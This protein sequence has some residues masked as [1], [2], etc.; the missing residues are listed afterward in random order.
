MG[1]WNET[2]FIV[3]YS[4]FIIYYGVRVALYRQMASGVSF[5]DVFLLC[6]VLI[7]PPFCE[8]QNVPLKRKHLYSYCRKR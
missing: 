7:L 6:S 5:S 8:P 4:L 2:F 1:M 3:H